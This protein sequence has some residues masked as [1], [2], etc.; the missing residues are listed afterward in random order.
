MARPSAP[1]R[2]ASRAEAIPAAVAAIV[3]LAAHASYV[4][5]PARIQQL[6]TATLHQVTGPGGA[7][8]PT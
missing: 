5:L 2:S 8:L 3:I 1:P 4:P 6:A 7:Q